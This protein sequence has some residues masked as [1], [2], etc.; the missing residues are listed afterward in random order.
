MSRVGDIFGRSVYLPRNISFTQQF[1]C[2]LTFSYTRYRTGR[3][4]LRHFSVRLQILAS[5]LIGKYLRVLQRTSKLHSQWSNYKRIGQKLCA[6]YC[7]FAN[8][9][10]RSLSLTL[11]LELRKVPDR[12]FSYKITFVR[13][14]LFY[15]KSKILVHKSHMPVTIRISVNMKILIWKNLKILITVLFQELKYFYINSIIQVVHLQTALFQLAQILRENVLPLQFCLIFMPRLLLPIPQR[16]R[17]SSLLHI[18]R[19]MFLLR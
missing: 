19:E 1:C 8:T 15:R 16:L 10:I 9:L 12:L 5:F 4:F 2:D 3:V 7:N 13:Q 18:L 17:S 6:N 14:L 11:D